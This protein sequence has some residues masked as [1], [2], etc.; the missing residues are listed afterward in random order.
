M[1]RR[2][3]LAMTLV[4][5]PKVI[6]LDEPTTGL[7]PRSRRTVW[8]IVRDLVS[9]GVTIFLR[10]TTWKRPTSSRTASRSWTAAG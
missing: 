1:R 8:R 7:D 10:R 3:D 5:E 4:G 6:F 9:R 2:L